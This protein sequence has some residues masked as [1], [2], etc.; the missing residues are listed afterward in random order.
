MRLFPLLLFLIAAGEL[1]GYHLA[2][3]YRN[4]VWFYNLLDPV[5]SLLYFLILYFSIISKHFKKIIIGSSVMFILVT[6]IS[7]KYFYERDLFNIWMYIFGSILLIV[8]VVFKIYE[9]LEDPA[10]LDFLKN[11]FF[12]ILIITLLFYTVTIPYMSMN[13][14]IANTEKSRFT[15]IL[16][17]VI[18]ILNYILY[19]TYTIAFLWIRKTGIY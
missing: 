1:Y 5:L 12:Y 9:L 3:V 7:Y 4:S 16:I 13:T 17:D 8:F 10:N 11:P 19:A 14:W 6:C 18:D 15:I 2:K